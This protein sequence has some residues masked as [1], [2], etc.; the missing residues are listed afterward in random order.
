M[1]PCNCIP[2]VSDIAFCC[3]E[4][5]LAPLPRLR[6]C[7]SCMYMYATGQ[8]TYQKGTASGGDFSDLDDRQDKKKKRKDSLPCICPRAPLILPWLP[9]ARVPRLTRGMQSLDS[10][11]AASTLAVQTQTMQTGSLSTPAGLNVTV[12]TNPRG[13]KKER[14]RRAGSFCPP[15]WSVCVCL[16]WFHD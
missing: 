8:V 1:W 3:V 10:Q 13:V 16:V 4:P 15:R 2:A 12:Q 14:K 9:T 6:P 5:R 7:S 11:Q